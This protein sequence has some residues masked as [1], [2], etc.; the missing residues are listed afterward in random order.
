MVVVNSC[1]P[2]RRG[3]S[4]VHRAH[5]LKSTSIQYIVLNSKLARRNIDH[6]SLAEYFIFLTH[7]R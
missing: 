5:R 2:F 6:Y 4:R 3:A 1:V 7:L